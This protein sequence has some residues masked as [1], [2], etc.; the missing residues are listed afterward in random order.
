LFGLNRQK[1]R[2]SLS[3]LQRSGDRVSVGAKVL[4]S[5]YFHN[6]LSSDHKPRQSPL[7][8]PFLAVIIKHNRQGGNQLARSNYQFNKRQKELAR[9]IK[10]ENKRQRKLDKNTITSEENPNQSPNE[11]ENPSA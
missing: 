10:K 2:N 6:S 5:F 3:S 1:L 7:I 9:K 8:G 11:E 4:F